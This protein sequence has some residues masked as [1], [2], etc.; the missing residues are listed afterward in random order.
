MHEAN[1]VLPRCGPDGLIVEREVPVTAGLADRASQ[2]RL[3]ALPRAVDQNGR[4]ISER[5]A[6]AGAR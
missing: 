3:A 5:L 2:R 1:R 6:K 4:S